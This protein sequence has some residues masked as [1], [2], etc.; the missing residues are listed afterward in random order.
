LAASANP[1][2]SARAYRLGAQAVYVKPS[3]LELLVKMS[4]SFE[5]AWT[6]AAQVS[7]RG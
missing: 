4:A 5:Q 3:T 7:S 6:A 2:D 1:A